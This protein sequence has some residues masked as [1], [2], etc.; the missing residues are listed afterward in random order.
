MM[1]LI[2]YDKTVAKYCEIFY[3]LIGKPI[4]ILNLLEKTDLYSAFHPRKAADETLL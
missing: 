4:C 3:S 2:E 1:T